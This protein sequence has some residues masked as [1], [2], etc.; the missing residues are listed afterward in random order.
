MSAPAM[1]MPVD[2]KLLLESRAAIAPLISSL[3]VGVFS[4]T[5]A[6]V[7]PTADDSVECL[8]EPRGRSRH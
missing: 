2:A 8:G 3:A 4:P 5:V 7:L 1:L 6:L